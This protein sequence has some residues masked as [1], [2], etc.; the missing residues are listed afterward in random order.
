MSV[1]VDTRTAGPSQI[2]SS[3]H[4]PSSDKHQEAVR[5]L[6]ICWLH[7]CL[8]KV[9]DKEEGET[10]L[11]VIKE[12]ASLRKKR[13]NR[14]TAITTVK[15]AKNDNLQLLSEDVYKS[16]QIKLVATYETDITSKDLVHVLRLGSVSG[17]GLSA[18]GATAPSLSQ[19]V[20]TAASEI[21][22]SHIL[23][24]AFEIYC[25][26]SFKERLIPLVLQ[27]YSETTPSG[28]KEKLA[29]TRCKVERVYMSDKVYNIKKSDRLAWEDQDIIRGVGFQKD[30][31]NGIMNSNEIAEDKIDAVEG[32]VATLCKFMKEDIG[33]DILVQLREIDSKKISFIVAQCK[34]RSPQDKEYVGSLSS[35]DISGYVGKHA[36][37]LEQARAVG[38]L[39]PFFFMATSTDF[40]AAETYFSKLIEAGLLVIQDAGVLNTEATVLN[41]IDKTI[42][43]LAKWKESAIQQQQKRIAE[44]KTRP[45]KPHQKDAV[46]EIIDYFVDKTG[47]RRDGKGGFVPNEEADTDRLNGSTDDTDGRHASIIMATG[48]GK[49]LTAY[50]ATTKLE[51]AHLVGKKIKLPSLH[52]SPM[53]RLVFQNAHEVS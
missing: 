25:S 48:S 19:G 24:E 40:S 4:V 43:Y 5:A 20:K 30:L 33:M 27:N 32:F 53:I 9:K 11:D 26:I 37:I 1:A 6:G 46:D 7:T 14:G 39:C 50:D 41:M 21:T 52:I 16:F 22:I 15:D 42:N 29:R 36:D 18:T 47:A 12:L 2:N 8:K 31:V 35:I 49:T 3:L 10:F 13:E 28:G 34:F 51:E 45:L 44:M 23:G 38:I 17:G